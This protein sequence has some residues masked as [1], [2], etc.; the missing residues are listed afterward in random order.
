MPRPEGG[1]VDV[2]RVCAGYVHMLTIS[3]FA[4]PNAHLFFSPCPPPPPP[5]PPLTP[6]SLC[7][8][9]SHFCDS[10][11]PIRSSYDV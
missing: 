1:V 3:P 4:R 6:L 2:R 8:C 5:P 9:M 10:D 7:V 11:L